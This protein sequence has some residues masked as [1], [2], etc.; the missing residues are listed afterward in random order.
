MAMWTDL[1]MGCPACA[2]KNN[3]LGDPAQ[4]YHANCGGA[5]EVSDDAVLRCKRDGTAYHI[6]S[7]RWGC[8][9]HGDPTRQDYYQATNSTATAAQ[10]SVAGALTNKMGKAWLMRFLDNLG[11]W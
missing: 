8:P 7:W 6:S 3:S 11:D 10:I 2:A 1:I 9:K 4:W 5:M